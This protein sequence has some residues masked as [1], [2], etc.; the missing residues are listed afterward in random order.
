MS[1]RLKATPSI[2]AR[3]KWARVCEAV[4]PANAARAWG[5]R[6]GVRSPKRYGAQS[7]PSLAAG[8]RAASAVNSSYA[9]PGAKVS[10]SQR[11]ERPAPL[12]T[13][14]TC[15]IPGTAWQ[16]VC[17]RP[18]RS[19]VGL[20]VAAKTTPLVPMVAETAPGATIPIPTAPAP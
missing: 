14:I 19:S 5:S 18:R 15:H 11:S 13:P 10:R 12:V 8:I 9:T 1:R 7:I 16:K 20:S 17:R 3:T 4:T 2:T 6:C